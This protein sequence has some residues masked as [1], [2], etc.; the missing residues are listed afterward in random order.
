MPDKTYVY[1]V[2]QRDFQNVVLDASFR[3][4]VLVDFWAAWCQPCQLLTP[5]LTRL[6]EV[7]QG[8]FVLAKVNADEEPALARQFGVRGLPTVKVFRNGAIVDERVGVQPESVYSQIIERHREKPADRL[9]AQAEQAWQQDKQ[10][11]AVR[12]LREALA[13]EP[14]KVELRLALIDKL[15]TVDEADAA[16]ELLEA[17]PPEERLQE[18]AISLET[19]LALW[20]I[21]QAAPPVATLEATVQADPEDCSARH[22]L[23]ARRT[24]AGDYEAALEQFLEILR[25]DPHFADDAGREGILA[26]FTTLGS[27]NPLVATY[28]RRMAALLH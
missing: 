9:Q 20:Q 27:D 26:I 16:R 18:T 15:I 22:Q 7:Y 28:R 1:D 3:V 25:R 10:Q 23:A 21:A 8:A 19:R 13:A 4:P 11:Q 2:T 24:M 17:L 6:A 12:L 14:N 5:L